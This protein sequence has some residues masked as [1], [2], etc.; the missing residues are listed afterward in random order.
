MSG[1]APVPLPILRIDTQTGARELILTSDDYHLAV[2]SV[3]VNGH[4]QSVVASYTLSNTLIVRSP[5]QQPLPLAGKT[6]KLDNV[7]GVADIPGT[8]FVVASSGD[9]GIV[10]IDVR[11]G[12]VVGHAP[13]EFFEA[14]HIYFSRT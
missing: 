12:S 9:R 5:G 3:E 8:P 1:E 10:A 2:Q 7:R 14:P 13:I 4:T 6:L 11:D